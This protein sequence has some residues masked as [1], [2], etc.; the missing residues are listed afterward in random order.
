MTPIVERLVT[1]MRR[2][3]GESPYA[4]DAEIILAVL[5]ALRAGV[6]EEMANEG[7]R[8]MCEIYFDGGVGYPR[9]GEA[10]GPGFQAAL[11]IAM[12]DQKS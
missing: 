9:I 12:G 6:T 10:F 4:A 7:A 1:T 3:R 2:A 8:V 11:D 5:R